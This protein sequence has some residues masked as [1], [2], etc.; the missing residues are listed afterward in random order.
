VAPNQAPIFQKSTLKPGKISLCDGAYC[1]AFF[2]FFAN[3]NKLITLRKSAGY[4]R[5]FVVSLVVKQRKEKD[6][7][8]LINKNFGMIVSVEPTEKTKD[9]GSWIWRKDYEDFIG[10]ISIYESQRI[11]KGNHFIVMNNDTRYIRTSVGK[12]TYTRILNESFIILETTNS[13]YTIKLI[14]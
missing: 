14:S 2:L 9:D 6:M 13:V 5:W 3:D 7:P 8:K 4:V 12:L 1:G 11:S 10:V